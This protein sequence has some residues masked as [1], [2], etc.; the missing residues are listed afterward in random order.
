MG[1]SHS[2]CFQRS[3]GRQN[4]ASPIETYAVRVFFNVGQKEAYEYF[5]CSDW[6]TGAV[7]Q[8]ANIV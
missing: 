3:Q 6:Y 4:T 2:G 1:L 8:D 7:L 5:T